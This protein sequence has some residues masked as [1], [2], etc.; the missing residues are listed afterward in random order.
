MVVPIDVM[1][2]TYL[3]QSERNYNNHKVQTNIW[4]YMYHFKNKKIRNA[5]IITIKLVYIYIFSNWEV[6]I[7]L[8]I[9]IW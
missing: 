4:G 9:A 6:T 8:C 3:T 2:Y 5:T 7:L 1:L